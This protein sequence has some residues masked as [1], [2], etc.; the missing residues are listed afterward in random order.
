LAAAQNVAGSST[1]RNRA[2]RRPR[3][4]LAIFEIDDALG[5]GA[6]LLCRNSFSGA[7][8]VRQSFSEG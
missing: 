8:L 2:H 5:G 3:P 4:I 7:W 6:W 1:L